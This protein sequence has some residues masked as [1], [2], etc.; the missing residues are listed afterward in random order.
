MPSSADAPK[1][2]VPL[3]ADEIKL[4]ANT[5][6]I[7]VSADGFVPNTFKVKAGQLVNFVLT[8][9]DNFT[10]IFTFND[11]ALTGAILGV[12]GNETRVKSWNAPQAGNYDFKCGVPGHSQRGETGVMIVE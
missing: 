2:S 11:S 7:S 4:T 8:S 9:T 12:A 5:I 3:Q 10:H 6:K 1:E